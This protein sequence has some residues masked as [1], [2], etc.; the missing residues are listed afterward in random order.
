M[1]IG[2]LIFF[3]ESVTE[4]IEIIFSETIP[5]SISKKLYK[6]AK[7]IDWNLVGKI[8]AQNQ[9]LL[10]MR[11]NPAT[12]KRGQKYAIQKVKGPDDSGEK[13]ISKNPDFAMA[14]F[15]IPVEG[16]VLY[17]YLLIYILY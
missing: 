16:R 1:K 10:R 7:S 5:L 4:L 11:S 2:F 13:N 8:W 3:S 12:K 15:G 14:T 6:I 9:P 17:F